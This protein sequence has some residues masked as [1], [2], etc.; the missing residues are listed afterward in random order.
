MKGALLMHH[1]RLP[2]YGGEM[3]VCLHV[4][5]RANLGSANRVCM[6]VGDA[7]FTRGS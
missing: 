6:G 3:Q 2:W 1:S 5:E 7:I 4:P